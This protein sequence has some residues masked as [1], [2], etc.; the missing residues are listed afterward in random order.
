LSLKPSLSVFVGIP[1]LT[2]KD[3]YTPLIQNAIKHIKAQKTS[4]KVLEPY[5]T[6]PYDGKFEV[7]DKSRLIA[8]TDRL[9]NVIE[10]F[11]GS[12]ATHLWL[13]D[14]DIEVPPHALETLLKLDSDI[15]S[16]IYAFHNDRH[17]FMFGRMK[18]DDTVQ[19]IPRGPPGFKGS[20]VIGDSFRVGGGNGCLLAKRRVFEQFHKDINPLRFYC[21][22]NEKRT[23]ASDIFFWYQV[24]KFGFTARIHGGVLC[25]HQPY[26]PLQSY[27]EEYG[28]DNIKGFERVS[29][30]L[31]NAG[32]TS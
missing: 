31:E 26:H 16:G 20:G 24:Q 1:S 32:K 4:V 12:K 8:I 23:W 25:G 9:N 2:R 3:N 14:G 13:V 5:V 29:L 6:P 10:E 7:G 27:I 17:I 28:E 18:D 19:F 21:P 11:L 22:V 30:E 15:A